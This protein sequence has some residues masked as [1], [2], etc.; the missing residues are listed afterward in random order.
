MVAVV[1]T[2]RERAPWL[3]HLVRAVG[4]YLADGGNRLAATVTYFGSLSLFPLLAISVALFGLVV[5]DSEDAIGTVRDAVDEFAPGL[6]EQLKLGAVLESSAT[7]TTILSFGTL[8]LLYSGLGFVDALRESV[9]SLWHHNVQAGFIVFK[10]AKDVVILAGLGATLVVSLAVSGF[11][12]AFA[13]TLLGWVGLQGSLVG[14]LTLTVVGTLLSIGVTWALLFYVYSRLPR[15]NDPA[16]SVA[17]AALLGA[18][19]FEVWKK[20]GGF[21]LDRTL[22]ND[23]YGAFAVAVGLLLWINITS[24]LVLLA[25]CWAVTAPYDSDV[26][27]SGTASPEL[28][29]EG[30]LPPEYAGDDPDQPPVLTEDGAPTPLRAAVEGHAPEREDED[31]TSPGGWPV[32]SVPPGGYPDGVQPTGGGPQP[33]PARASGGVTTASDGGRVVDDSWRLGHGEPSPVVV[34]F[35]PEVSPQEQHVRRAAQGVLVAGG[36]VLAA[37]GAVTVRAL[38]DLVRG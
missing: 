32:P 21:Y 11:A 3:D 2:A 12:G 38:R 19:L 14:T 22:G 6:Y 26:A 34:R 25:A 9:R 24:R 10:K 35:D 15:I 16:G 17:R 36:A 29:A 18:V 20:L 28:A 37:A 30:G 7:Q 1:D 23:L 8:G 31:D 13:D 33:P 4:R 5:G 27:P